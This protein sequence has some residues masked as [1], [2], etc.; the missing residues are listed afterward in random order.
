M[1]EQP[2]MPT[3]LVS[4]RLLRVDTALPAPVAGTMRQILPL[5]HNPQALTRTG[6][7]KLESDIEATKGVTL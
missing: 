5:R 7:I 2:A 3:D 6:I 1:P 4:A